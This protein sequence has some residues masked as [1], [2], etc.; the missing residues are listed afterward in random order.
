MDKI[1]FLKLVGSDHFVIYDGHMED[2][3]LPFAYSISITTRINLATKYT[4]Y[5]AYNN[6]LVRQG[7]CECIH[8]DVLQNV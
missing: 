2:E 5:D 6:D 8:V 4:K 7:I 1:Y 3:S